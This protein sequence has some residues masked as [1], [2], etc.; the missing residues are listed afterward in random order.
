MRD[1]RF[2]PDDRQLPR[3]NSLAPELTEI[4]RGCL[5]AREK[6]SDP[7]VAHHC[8]WTHVDE[9]TLHGSKVALGIFQLEPS[10]AL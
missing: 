10:V 2:D 8:T 1:R 7:L 5:A 6:D 4:E 9:S 3:L